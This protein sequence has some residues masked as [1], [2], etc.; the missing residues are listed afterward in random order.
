[1]KKY[2]FLLAS[3]FILAGCQSPQTTEE[4]ISESTISSVMA[5]TITVTMRMSIDGEEVEG[6]SQEIQVEEGAILLDV[7]KENYD[8]EETDGFITSIDGQEQDTEA[9]KYWLFDING[10]MAPVGANETELQEGDVVEWKL[11]AM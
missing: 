11:E 10:E 4:S 1:M 5:E 7:M 3:G 9:G 6:G 2:L 8:I